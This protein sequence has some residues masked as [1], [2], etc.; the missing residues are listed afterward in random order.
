MDLIKRQPSYAELEAL[1]AQLQLELAALRAEHQ[2]LKQRI[3]EL[4]KENGSC[5]D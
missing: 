5:G 2:G 4:E 3:A 1:V